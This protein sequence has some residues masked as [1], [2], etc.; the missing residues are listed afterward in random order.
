MER[1]AAPTADTIDRSTFS[2]AAEGKRGA[3]LSACRE[4]TGAIV[5]V[6]FMTLSGDRI[7]GEV[8]GSPL[9]S[10]YLQDVFNGATPA[11]NCATTVAA[12]EA[13][14]QVPPIRAPSSSSGGGSSGGSDSGSCQ[15][16]GPIVHAKARISATGITAHG[17]ASNRGCG[18]RIILVGVAVA[19]SV[20][21]RC[22]FLKANGT[23]A[24]PTSCRPRD[25]LHAHGTTR[26]T[27]QRRLR[28]AKGVYFVWAHATNSKHQT[29]R[30]TA[31]KHI[32]LRVR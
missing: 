14:P 25:F 3:I 16:G 19:R 9:V 30:N 11:S 13:L 2:A 7:S 26:W 5:P 6:D 17:V 23:F 21:H 8:E 1:R 28:L 22:R 20:G 15:A 24:K 12:A 18:P 4:L 31:R 27:Y 29:T 32:F 10:A